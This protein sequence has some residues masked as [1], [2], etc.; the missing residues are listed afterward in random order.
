[1]E[2]R[3]EA[4]TGVGRMSG[5]SL[6]REAALPRAVWLSGT[7]PTLVV[8]AARL[9]NA[10]QRFC[11]FRQR[12]FD[13]KISK[14]DNTDEAFVTVHDWQTPD[15]KFRHVLRNVSDILILKAVLD[16]GTHC[17]SDFRVGT[18]ALGHAADRNV[19]ISDHADE[20]IIFSHRQ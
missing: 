7:L 6:R 4:R 5:S 17:V 9:R 10:V 14:R 12:T 20:L 16:L 15:L 3:G 19:A 11:C 2:D 8:L 18:F 13:R 1:M